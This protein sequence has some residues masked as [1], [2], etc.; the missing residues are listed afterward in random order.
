MCVL[1]II[2]SWRSERR[3][4]RRFA[5]ATNPRQKLC[6]DIQGFEHALIIVLNTLF[7]TILSHVCL[8]IRANILLGNI[9]LTYISKHGLQLCKNNKRHNFKTMFKAFLIYYKI[10]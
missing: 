1:C 7:Y 5:E 2:L 4:R 8:Y 3:V 9:M 6:N 10:S